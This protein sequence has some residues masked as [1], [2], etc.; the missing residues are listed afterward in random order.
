MAVV[1]MKEL[2]EAGVHFGHQTSR[3]HPKMAK[4]IY[5]GK[6]GIHIIDLQQTIE[7]LEKA[8]QFAKEVVISGK[9]VLFV[10]TKKQAQEVIREAAER[11]GMP[12]IVERWMGGTLTNFPVVM[13]GVKRLERL[14]KMEAEGKFET[15][16]KRQAKML[17]KQ[18]EKTRKNL[19]GIRNMKEL[20][21]AIFLVD[22]RKEET[23]LKEAKRLG[24]PVIALVDTNCDPAPVDY[25]IPGN[26][27]A[28]RSIKL[29]ADKLAN[30]IQEA[31]ELKEQGAVVTEEKPEEAGESESERRELLE[32]VLKDE[33]DLQTMEFIEE[34]MDR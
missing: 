28:I 29:I 23:P 11:C 8:C 3:W 12:Y 25:L 15:L 13:N 32:S 16:P 24:I 21:G 7:L 34:E 27:D 14:E 4:Y 17:R 1:T 18:L 31:K 33:E 20:P 19:G 26:D 10:G 9:D 22:I 6:N 30:A 5:A 2:L